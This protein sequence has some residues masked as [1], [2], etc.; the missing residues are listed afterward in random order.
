MQTVRSS[1]SVYGTG[2][3]N[4]GASVNTTTRATTTG[5][6][7]FMVAYD[8]DTGKCWMGYEGTWW[9]GDPAAGTSQ[10]F[11]ASAPMMPVLVP[12]NDGSNGSLANIINFG[13]QPF[14]YTA[15]SGFLPLNTFNL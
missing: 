12:Y 13:Q 9:S 7:I 10:Y 1:I 2:L 15:P 8:A 4:S 14:V 3:Y 6:R 11:T 5:T